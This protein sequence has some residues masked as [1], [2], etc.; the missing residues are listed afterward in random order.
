MNSDTTRGF[1][2]GMIFAGIIFS[3]VFFGLHKPLVLED[4]Y[5]QGQIDCL[6][7]KIQYERRVT[8][9][10]TYTKR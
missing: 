8:T 10:T 6:N 2:G 7:G 9:D 3:A 1:S 5:K 4:A